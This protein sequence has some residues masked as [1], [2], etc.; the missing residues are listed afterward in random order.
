M[1]VVGRSVPRLE[2]RPLV[3]GRG[4]YAA[5]IAFPHQLHMRVVRSPVAHGRI[6]AID[7]GAALAL[8]GVVAVWTARDVADIPPIDFRL[9]KIEGLAAYRQTILTSD[10]VRYV[11]DPVAA[12]FAADP[13]VA[14]DAAD[15]VVLDIEE[16]P[17]LLDASGAVGTFEPGRSTEAAVIEKSYGD[18]DGAFRSAHAVVEF[19]GRDRPALRRAAGDPRRHRPLRCGARCPGA[20]RRS[21]GAAL[22][23]RRHRADA[24]TRAVVRAPV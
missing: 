19:D 17:A 6:V 16:L 14:E 7:A 23:P 9:S 5:D 21:E 1:G 4:M 15:L 11:G 2:D 20:A 8:P 22:E 10:C 24:G 3:T 13:Y 12:V 18:I